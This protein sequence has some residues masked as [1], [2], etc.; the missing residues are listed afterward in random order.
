MN[1][2][3]SI[4]SAGFM[5]I[6]AF[7]HVQPLLHNAEM[8]KGQ[9]TC[10]KKPE[11]KPVCGK[12]TSCPMQKSSEKKDEKEKSNNC[13]SQG[14][15]PF[16]PC[17]SSTCCYLVESFFPDTNTSVSAKQKYTPFNDNRLLNNL[18]ECWQPPEPVS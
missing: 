15:N 16:T 10:T 4:F 6:F 2:R 1:L 17:A 5:I 3:S 9:T 13:D 11:K 12:K 18:S 14:C 7:L 8:K